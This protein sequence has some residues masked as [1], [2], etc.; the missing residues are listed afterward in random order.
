MVVE[1]LHTGSQRHLQGHREEISCLAV[2]N[3]AQ[4]KKIE[5]ETQ[6]SNSTGMLS[7]ILSDMK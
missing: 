2:T 3:D 4:V 5:F 1:D 6:Y 7:E